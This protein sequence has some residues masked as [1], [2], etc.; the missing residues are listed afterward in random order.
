[1]H[2]DE[3][4]W[5]SW[6]SWR[7]VSRK[8]VDGVPRE[9]MEVGEAGDVTIT[10]LGEEAGY[11]N[12]LFVYRIGDGGTFEDVRLL[13]ADTSEKI[14]IGGRSKGPQRDGPLEVGDSIRL[15][16]LYDP[17]QIA[18][19]QEFGLL[20]LP[21]GYNRNP[22]GIFED[23]E[24]F[25][26]IDRRTGETAD[27]DTPR[28]RIR[29]VHEGEEG[30]TAV[31]GKLLFTTDPRDDGGWRNPLN[32][33]GR[34]HVLSRPGEEEGQTELYFEDLVRRRG[35]Y[36][37]LKL[38]IDTDPDPLGPCP[39]RLDAT[40]LAGGRG[41]LAEG[42]NAGDR[43]GYAV[44]AIGDFDGDGFGDV[45]IAAPHA[46]PEG[47]GAVY[48]L[49]GR[50]ADIP[51]TVQLGGAGG[52]AMSVLF[53]AAAGDLLG[54][55]LAAAGDVDGDG[56]DDLL[57]GAVGLDGLAPDS[58]GAYLLLGG[59]RPGSGGIEALDPGRLIRIDGLATGD[60]LGIA[61]AGG[62]DIDGDGFDDILIGARLAEADYARYSGGLSYLLFGGPDGVTG[63][64]AALDGTDGMRITGVARFDQ[65]GRAVAV[66]GDV[67]GDGFD[68]LAVGA[69]DAD[70]A[71]RTNAGEIYVVYGAEDGFPAEL[72]PSTMGGG[73]FLVS[74]AD[75]FDFAGF[76]V[77]G[78]GDVNG[79]GFDD[80]VIGAYARDTGGGEAA[81]AAYLVFGSAE[82]H[83]DGLDLGDL[84]GSN[85]F[86]MFGLSAMSGTG[87]AVA[88]AGD[89]NGDGFDDF[90][91]GA[92]YAD[93]E[94]VG[95]AGE[96]YLIYG[97]P[98][99]FDAVLD[100]G[101]LEEDG[102]GCRLIGTAGEAYAGFSFG[103]PG[104][105]DGDGFDDLVIGAPATPG[106][107]EAGTAF[108]VFGGPQ[109]A[110]AI[111]ALTGDIE[112]LV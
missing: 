25:R 5:E 74:G 103:G 29:L 67:N 42:E 11:R 41:V 72:D 40:G 15:S 24:G 22:A 8:K 95:G 48:L 55:S 39:V 84:D 62:G 44:A 82:G 51:D 12:S 57:I 97:R 54:S 6:R 20:L 89:V 23:A 13:W 7:T 71:G 91:V 100:L 90:V 49:F 76:A 16:E 92:R 110:P 79:D 85:G 68:D 17:G 58:G 94:G 60:E 70:P 109:F 69:P 1:M 88:G 108:A 14:G 2:R 4:W 30:D 78:A 106:G 61:V 65:S 18:P 86:A 9:R 50:D 96:V 10:F 52:G 32:P 47:Q 33:G 64:L 19:G 93:P 98:E 73:G 104:D 83:P 45:A 35:D 66:L 37:D 28:W 107:E 99:P 38:L 34:E 27:L 81:G 26:L 77:A 111:A 53:G 105:I 21:D 87:R 36:N 80:F 31:R 46:G 43:A 101:S 3:D 63:D 56:F 102:A 59:L 112:T 75:P